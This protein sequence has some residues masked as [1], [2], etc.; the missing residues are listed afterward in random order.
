MLG[1]HADRLVDCGCPGV[2]SCMVLRGMT[3]CTQ[4]VAVVCCYCL[5][6][7]TVCYASTAH[8]VA[9]HASLQYCESPSTVTHA[10]PPPTI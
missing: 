5:L 9:Q 3:L 4:H 1:L 2:C 6:P 10:P 7:S 8:C